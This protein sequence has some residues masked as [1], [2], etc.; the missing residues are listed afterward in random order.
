MFELYGYAQIAV[1]RDYYPLFIKEDFQKALDYARAIDSLNKRLGT[2]SPQTMNK[3]AYGYNSPA[4]ELPLVDL[5]L[6][7]KTD[8]KKVLKLLELQKELTYSSDTK[9]M[10]RNN[11]D[12]ET[13]EARLY[14]YVKFCDLCRLA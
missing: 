6:N 11:S 12:P 7:G 5:I 8:E 10:D 14:E 9:R 3:Y 2:D 13:L 1:L 4:F